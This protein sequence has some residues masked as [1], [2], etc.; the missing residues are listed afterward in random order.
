[1]KRFFNFIV[2]AA[3]V[4]VVASCGNYKY[5]SVKD[6]PTGA[7][8]YTLDNGLK[9]YM[10]VNKDKPRIDAQ[11]AVKVG[12]KNDPRE[13]T[14]LAHYFEH[15]MFK[16]TRQFGTQNYEQEKPMLDEIEA[17]FEVYRQ[18]EDPAERKAIYHQIDS[19]SYEASKIAIPNEYDKL[20]ASIGA[21]GTNAYTS[22][23]VTCYVENI[24]SNQ[25]EAWA[26]IQADRFEN[27]VL[28]GFHTE[29]ETIY[30]E[31]NMYNAQDGTKASNAMFE[32]L[33]KNHPYNTDVIGLPSHLKNPSI[34]NVKRYHDEWYV[35]NNMAVVLSGDFNPDQA[36][37]IINKYFGGMKPNE[38]LKKMEFEPE[39]PITEPV[40]KE[41]V[42]NE[43]PNIMLAWR[44]PGANSPEAL[45]LDAMSNV[46]FNGK[47]GLID[48]DVNQQQKTLGMYAGSYNLADYSM[49][50]IE[51]EPKTGQSLEEVKA[52]ALA[53][54]EKV[55]AGDFDEGLLTATINNLK[56]NYMRRIETPAAMARTAVNCFINDVPW[57]DFVTEIDR[58]SKITKDEIVKFANENF[59]DNYVQVNKL[60]G[61][62]KDDGSKIDKPAITPIFTNRDTSSQFLRDMQAAAAA[63]KPIE[64]V[65]VDYSKDMSRL[66]A[67]N[68]IEVLYKQNVTNGIFELDYRFE[69]G[70]YADMVLPYACTYAQYLG[71][72]KMS[73]EEVKKYLYGIACDMYASCSGEYTYLSLSGLSENMEE[74]MRF[75]E[76]FVAD[77]QPNPQ[78]L[79]MMKANTLQERANAKTDQRSNSSRLQAYCL[80]GPENP[81]THI[82]PAAELIALTDEQLIEKIHNIF[83]AQHNVLYYG[84]MKSDELVAKVN[85][86]HN[87]PETLAPVVKGNPFQYK[88][89]EENMVYTAPFDANQSILYSLSCQGEKYDASMVPAVSMY[90]EYFGGGMNSIVF[91]EMREARGLAYSA[92]ARYNLPGDLDHTCIFMD[93]IQT[94]NDKLVDALTAFDDIINNMPVSQNAFDIAKESIISNLRTQRTVKS[95]VL[96]SY[97]NAQ[98]LGLDYD[99]NRD[100]YEKVQGYTLDDVVKF[101]QD[102][103]KGRKYTICILGRESDFDKEGLSKFG[104][105]K[106]VST[107]EIFGY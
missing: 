76:E 39:E 56:L 98:R 5:E 78:A 55:K 24:P 53:E 83:S 54:I 13:T 101:Q 107:E 41:V 58:L 105:I 86:I 102:N 49:F 103:I 3:L 84:P 42:G 73:P 38:N 66:D 26:K 89:T 31:F 23:D 96:W 85:E 87:C 88:L 75:M 30:E 27:C 106:H 71:T 25:I 94:Q 45:V 59:S 90:N 29:L 1:M 37:K 34:T 74:A 19:I 51:S 100:I 10:I 12:S 44:F 72:S 8:I 62:P 14:G 92:A 43:S 32:G 63:V 46:L 47:A 60:Q 28:R 67:K 18:T 57:S 99:I 17:L 80:Y 77:A 20:M 95:S 93:Y 64:P 61:T 52:I 11:I 36:I 15:L 9:V 33:F 97:V 104:Q 16:G 70:S 68:G 69:T 91:Q 50:Y 79:A 82:L 4:A 65:F 6:D 21:S 7:R 35:P 2:M 81:S 48:L 40:I 22:F